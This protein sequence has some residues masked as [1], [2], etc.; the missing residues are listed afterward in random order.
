MSGITLHPKYGLNPTMGVCFWCGEEDGT[1]GLLGRNKGREAARKS[2]LSLQPCKKCADNMAL[3]ITVVECTTYQ[4]D[5]WQV[6]FQH[7][8]YPTGRWCVVKR[9]AEFWGCINEPMRS[10]VL[11]KGKMFLEPEMYE[12]FGF[13]PAAEKKEQA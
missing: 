13:A 11:K 6:E 1:I 7:G 8:A 10:I 12:Q 4:R 2:I 3:G 5:P 9:D